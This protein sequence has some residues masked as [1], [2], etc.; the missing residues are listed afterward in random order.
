MANTR[1]GLLVYGVS[2]DK[3]M[4][5]IDTPAVDPFRYGQ[6]LR[7]HVRPFLADVRYEV[8]RSADQSVAVLVVEVPASEF[9]PH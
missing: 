3:E 9:A 5:G 4:R 2:D 7:N 6:W 8:L 1:G